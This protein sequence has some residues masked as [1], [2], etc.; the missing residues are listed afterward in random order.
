MK[1]RRINLWGGPGCGKSTTSAELFSDI[2]K[3]MINRED[4][5]S[6]ELV[7]EF[8]KEYAWTEASIS[9]FDQLIIST[10]QLRREYQL[11]RDNRV[12]MIVTDSPI[13]LGYVY[14]NLYNAHAKEAILKSSLEFE[15]E[16]PSI[17]I[18]ITRGDRPYDCRGR[19]QDENGA[20][21]IDEEISS[22]FALI[23]NY[24]I[25]QPNESAFKLVKNI[26][27]WD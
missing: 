18:Y 20:R 19:Y 12:D 3:Y 5:I 13:H 2:K 14:A 21:E 25:L 11:L 17:N 9:G 16:F 6:I 24:H 15:R 26:L 10:E 23:P 7:R 4:R 1:I 22:W 27:K 8:A